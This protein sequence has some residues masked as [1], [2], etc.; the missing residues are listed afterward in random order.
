MEI[1][2]EQDVSIEPLQGKTIAVLGYGTTKLRF[3]TS[4]RAFFSDDNP[5]LLAFENVENTYVKKKPKSRK[6][7]PMTCALKPA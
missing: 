1:L 7:P 4:Y 5:E 2:K 3:D 6:K